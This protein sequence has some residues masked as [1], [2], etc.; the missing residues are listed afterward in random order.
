MTL[1]QPSALTI[2]AVIVTYYPDSGFAD[3]VERVTRQ[4]G[5]TVIVD[6]GSQTSCLEQIRKVVGRL[7]IH[8]IPNASNQGIARALNAGVRWA[9]SQGFRWVLTLDQ[10]TAVGPDMVD[11]L[12]EVFRVYPL[13]ERVAVI[14]SNFRHKVNEKVWF[15]EADGPKYSPVKEMETVLTSGSLVSVDVFEA[16]GGFR[17]D[18]FIDCVD[19][20]YCLRARSRGYRVLMTSK[21]VMEH[22]LGFLTE[23]RLLWRTVGTTNHSPLR[24]YFMARNTLILAREYIGNEPQWIL[25]YLWASAKSILLVCLFE[26]ERVSKIKSTIRG[27]IDGVL[28]RTSVAGG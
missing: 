26:E 4:V 9:A 14:G 12:A 24:R 2:C 28:G 19:H 27:C 8:L 20:E 18:F 15:N 16:I 22:G 21:P 10:D 11:S 25:R 5:R 17:D 7:G 6:N 1:P 13:P 23:H 3:R